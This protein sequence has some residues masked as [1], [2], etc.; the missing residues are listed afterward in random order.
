M[1]NDA[2]L[3]A[4][5]SPLQ[6]LSDLLAKKPGAAGRR[7]TGTMR[8]DTELFELNGGD[9]SQRDDLFALK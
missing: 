1:C 7:V 4:S 5:L 3:I 6:K 2:A 8:I 9:L